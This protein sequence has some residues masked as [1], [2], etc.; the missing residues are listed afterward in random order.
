ML[1]HIEEA[2]AQRR[3]DLTYHEE[4]NITIRPTLRPRLWPSRAPV[5]P[6]RTLAA[7]GEALGAA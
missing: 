1:A 7:H 5:H 3:G 6:D 4:V 2:V